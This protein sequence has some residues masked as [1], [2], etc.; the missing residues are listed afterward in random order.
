[1]WA[2]SHFIVGDRA[3]NETHARHGKNSLLRQH[4]PN[5]IPQAPSN[6]PSLARR[7]KSGWGAALRGPG[8]VDLS[9]SIRMSGGLDRVQSAKYR[10]GAESCWIYL[11]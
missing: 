2:Q 10:I 4:S 9:H 8:N 1:M 5:G 11:Y 7:R 6:N 3:Q